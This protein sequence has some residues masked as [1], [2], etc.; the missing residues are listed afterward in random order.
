MLCKVLNS[1]K[2]KLTIGRMLNIIDNNNNLLV[3][4]NSL[5]LYIGPL[6]TGAKYTYLIFTLPIHILIY[7]LLFFVF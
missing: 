4:N 5:I 6:Q 2:L 3:E 1:E 7:L